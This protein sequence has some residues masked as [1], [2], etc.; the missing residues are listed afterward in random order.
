M[1]ATPAV[2][3]LSD[4]LAEIV[5]LRGGNL[6]CPASI[7]SMEEQREKNFQHIWAALQRLN[8]A[9]RAECVRNTTLL[10][11]IE[12]ARK[13]VCGNPYTNMFGDDPREALIGSVS[14]GA[15]IVTLYRFGYSNMENVLTLAILPNNEIGL[16]ESHHAPDLRFFYHKRVVPSENHPMTYSC[17]LG[18][19][20]RELSD[21]G[22]PGTEEFINIV[23]YRLQQ[24]LVGETS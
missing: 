17:I 24:I 12:L 20:L 13:K 2:L 11:I 9:F 15:G 10:S 21:T 3:G 7:V 19:W 6:T 14:S 18:Q 8:A 1:N 4:A 23:L 5:S 16:V 22:S